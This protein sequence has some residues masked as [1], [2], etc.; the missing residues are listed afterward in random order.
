MEKAAI[1]MKVVHDAE[2]YVVWRW[3]LL[4]EL[5]FEDLA[6][7]RRMSAQFPVATSNILLSSKSALK[8]VGIWFEEA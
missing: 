2:L 8:R 7:R 5:L 4:E 6:R 3:P 1:F